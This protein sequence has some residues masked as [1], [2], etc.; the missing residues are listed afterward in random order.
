MIKKAESKPKI[1]TLYVCNNDDGASSTSEIGS[2]VDRPSLSLSMRDWSSLHQS[3]TIIGTCR[4][5]LELSMPIAHGGQGEAR[6][7]NEARVP[8][9]SARHADNE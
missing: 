7:G 2:R 3:Q 1:Y 6:L 5:S 8:S 4:V 9:F